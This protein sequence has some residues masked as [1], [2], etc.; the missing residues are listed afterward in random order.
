MK[1]L[2]TTG[3]TKLIELSKDTFLDKDN[4]VNVSEALSTVAISGSYNDLS[5]KP[6]INSITLSGNKTSSDLGLQPTLV[7]SGTGQNI[8]TVNN[9]NLLGSGNIN[10]DSLPTQSGNSGKFLTTNGT[11]A[12]WANTPTE[13]PAQSGNSGK[14]LTTNGTSVSWGSIGNGTITIT[15]GSTTKSF[16][17]NQST[18]D[19]ITLS[20]GY[21][22]DTVTTS[23]NGSNQMQADGVKNKNTASGATENVYD[24]IGTISEYTT[25][26]VATNHPDWLCFITDDNTDPINVYSKSEIDAK[27][28]NNSF[29]SIQYYSTRSAAL[30]ASQADPTKLCLYPL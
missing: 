22:P 8:K 28:G 12:S 13:I 9:N 18:N 21:A 1:V 15:Q 27:L 5:N 16:T 29:K 17:M 10:I 19:T 14:F 23:L 30:A 7:G 24:W 25:Q 20:Q 6:S 26:A 3:L 4:I 2:T 11:T